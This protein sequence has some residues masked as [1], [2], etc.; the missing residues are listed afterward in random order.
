[1]DNTVNDTHKVVQL[2]VGTRRFEANGTWYTVTDYIAT[3]RYAQYQKAT[4]TYG[5]AMNVKGILDFGNKM[6][7][8][9]QKMDFGTCAVLCYNLIEGFTKIENEEVQA[10][11]VCSLFINADGEDARYYDK[12]VAEKKIA[13]WMEAGID[14]PF[15][16]YHSINSVLGYKDVWQK[17]S[18]T[19]SETGKALPT[20]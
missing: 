2:A 16:I 12:A 6:W 15:F 19:T 13:D 18:R 1:M 10:F 3:G 9:I 17:I 11:E 4:A 5:F 20:T 7:A 14:T 8:A